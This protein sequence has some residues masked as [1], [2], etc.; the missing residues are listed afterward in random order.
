MSVRQFRLVAMVT[1]SACLD[2]D[3]QSNIKLLYQQ[4][5]E[6]GPDNLIGVAHDLSPHY[7]LNLEQFR[8][9]H[10]D[11][12]LGDP[13]WSQGFNTGV[14][15]YNLARMR[16][17]EDYNKLLTAEEVRRVINKYG[18]TVS[19]GDQDWFT[20][21]GYE[22]NQMFYRLPCQFNA[23]VSVQYWR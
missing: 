3:I 12:T 1:P 5:A 14:V 22:A 23:Q 11:S 4:F 21:I 18:Y 16:E 7:R 8:R 19:L 13:G 6:F 20:N 15:L 2:L 9:W 17:S 10:P